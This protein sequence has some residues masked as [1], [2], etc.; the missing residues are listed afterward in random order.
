LRC[1]RHRGGPA[2]QG[3]PAPAGRVNLI[4][5]CSG[6][7]PG[8]TRPADRVVGL[9]DIAALAVHLMT[10]TA[11]TGATFDIDGG[12]QLIEG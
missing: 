3:S 1:G 5:N 11:I 6:I 8:A 12:Q 10:N 9:A 7:L 2:G 4:V